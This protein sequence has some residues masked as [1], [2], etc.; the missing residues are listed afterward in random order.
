GRLAVAGLLVLAQ[1]SW[2]WYLWVALAFLV[3][4]GGWSHPSVLAPAHP[5]P[6][7]RRWIGWL[8]ILVLVLTFVPVP[9]PA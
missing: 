5:V 8:A 3:G 4:R 2:S 1:F 6:V 7:R 9:F